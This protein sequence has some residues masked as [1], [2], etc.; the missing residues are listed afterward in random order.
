VSTSPRR[1][2]LLIPLFSAPSSDSWGVGDIGD[3]ASLSRWLAGGG[4]RILQLLPLNEMA[5]GYHSPYSAMSAM[6]IDPMYIRVPDVAEFIANGGEASLDDDDRRRLQQA[7]QALRVEYGI[8]RA[9][10]HHALC[11][12]FERFVDYELTPH[13]ARA[14]AFHAYVAAESWWL[15][16]YTLFRAIHEREKGRAW[17]EWP[18]GLRRRKRAALDEARTELARQ[19]LFYQYL[20]WLAGTQWKQ[21]RTAARANG[22][23][24]FGDVPF[25]VDLHSADVWT[26][27]E[28]FELDRSVGVPPDAFSATG[29]DW[30]MPPYNWEAFARHGFVWLHDRARRS[31]ALYDGYRVD[32][33]VGFYRTYSRPRVEDGK[34]AF[35]PAEESDQLELGEQVLAIFR[36]AGSEIIAEDLG[37]VPDFVRASL[38]DLAVPGFRV[39]RWE[40]EWD[41]EGMPFHDPL[42]YP[43]VSVATTGTHDTEPM[44]VWWEAAEPEER[45]AVAA[46]PSIQ[47]LVA[48][49]DLLDAP[50]IP[51]VR[52]TLIEVLFASASDVVLFPVQDIFGWRD[53]INEPAT[54]SDDNWTYR[55][56]WPVDQLDA[57]PEAQERQATLLGWAVKHDRIRGRNV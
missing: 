44:I 11:A 53:R 35:S 23:A 13:T 18:E 7:R 32:H 25:M 30:G 45:A 17:I 10:K 14:A 51:T 55:L 2:G 26:H 39:F 42:E 4:Q 21:A 1:S 6:A 31:A 16:N 9:V 37:T 28:H 34:P 27:Q 8:L 56:P 19:V 20:Q 29:Q 15:A 49:A 41:E 48:G 43:E 5:S 46:V 24:L 38:K 22:V 50:F 40:R 33:L 47:D 52:D 54:V 3:I 36:E 57:Q 12:A